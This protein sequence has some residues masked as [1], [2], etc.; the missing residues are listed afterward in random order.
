MIRTA[1]R[2]RSPPGVAKQ[3]HPAGGAGINFI[4]RSSPAACAGGCAG[5]VRS[6][7]RHNAPVRPRPIGSGLSYPGFLPKRR[8]IALWTSKASS[9]F[10]RST[11]TS[12]SRSRRRV[13]RRVGG[14]PPAPPELFSTP[15][16]NRGHPEQSVNWVASTNRESDVQWQDL[17][18][19]RA[20][21]HVTA[22]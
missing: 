6:A 16:T 19:P 13:T 12:L 2:S 14:V 11:F 5:I 10:V 20:T 4:Q 18:V 9:A 7:P 3:T 15:P 1:T 8:S 22:C 21:S 17:R